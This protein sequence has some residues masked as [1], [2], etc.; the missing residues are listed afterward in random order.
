[1]HW[2]TPCVSIPLY[3]TSVH[4][5]WRKIRNSEIQ[6]MYRLSNVVVGCDHTCTMSE[7]EAGERAKVRQG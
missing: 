6:P 4:C 7:A 1:M 2:S 5:A 3:I